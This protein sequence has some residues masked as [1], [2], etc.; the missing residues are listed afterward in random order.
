MAIAKVIAAMATSSLAIADVEIVV[1]YRILRISQ[2][3]LSPYV[4]A[5][6]S[7]VSGKLIY[8]RSDISWKSVRYRGIRSSASEGT[9]VVE[10]DSE[11]L[12]RVP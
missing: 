7:D 11:V 10:S 4:H 9:R 6:A 5:E 2:I 8:A 12:S 1:A 3:P